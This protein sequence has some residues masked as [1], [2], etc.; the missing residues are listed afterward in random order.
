MVALTASCSSGVRPTPRPIVTFAPTPPVTAEIVIPGLKAALGPDKP[1]RFK[2]TGIAQVGEVGFAIITE[3]DFQGGQMDARVS[4]RVMNVLVPW[5]VM[6]V[7]GKTYVRPNGGK[8]R[9]EKVKTPPKG[10]GPFGDMSD[11]NLVFKGPS[12]NDRRFY[13]VVWKDPANANR[14]INGTIL[15][16]VK[17][18]SSVITFQVR[19][20]GDPLQ[21]TYT[22][23]G[24]GTFDGRSMAVTVEGLYTFFAVREPLVFKAPIK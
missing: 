5:D 11:A 8:W 13:T 21:A 15:T 20:N 10:S 7:D 16:G 12:K 19:S 2:D 3:G 4:F 17:I 6:A 14:V 22:M 24:T 18:K 23:K 9:R 1:I